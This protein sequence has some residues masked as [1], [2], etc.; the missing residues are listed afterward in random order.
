MASTMTTLPGQFLSG[1]RIF[2]AGGGIGSLA[3]VSALDQLWPQNLSSKRPEVTVFE[4]ET[5]QDSIQKANYT[6]DITGGSPDEG[7]FALQQLGL[8]D[9]IRP[10]STL[11][12]GL[13]NVWSDKWKFLADIA[14]KAY[15]N[16][17]AATMRITREN[18][19]RILLENAEK[20]NAIF[21]WQSTCTSAERLQNGQIRVTIQ[22]AEAGTTHTEDCDLLIAAD[23]AN[24]K[25][26]E[27]FRPFD[28]K[29]EYSGATQIG[30]ISRL[31]QGL[32]HPVEED[33]GLQMSSGEGVCCIYTPFDAETIGWAVS[34]TGPARDAHDGPF[35]A[36]EFVALKNEALKTAS[37][38]DEPFK[39]IVEAT[40]PSTAFIRPAYEKQP[41]QHDA[42]MRGVV[43]IGDANRVV[44]PFVLVGANLALKDGWD[45]AEQLCYNTSLDSAVAGYD[46]LSMPRVEHAI[47]FSHERVRF[48]HSSGLMWKVYK[49]GMAAQRK[50]A[51]K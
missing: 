46:R 28:L 13:I 47:K 49:Y 44:N 24:S 48:G 34:K 19:K 39:T 50:I 11:N 25:I 45:V 29:M 35:T 42:R 2:V 41:F 22:D 23:G 27:T 4:R 14:P 43:F 37:M 3:F 9:S 21:Q 51:K 36:E 17:P 8:L 30:G 18:L 31:T 10:Y 12:S 1:K 26:R 16:L 38:F 15:G 6:L 20:G 40:D 5:R 7:L 32:P 33:Y